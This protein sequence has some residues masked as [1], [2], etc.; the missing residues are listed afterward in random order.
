MN[1]MLRT[2]LP[3]GHGAFY[4]EQ[5]KIKGCDERINIVYD[6][7]GNSE[8][9][10]AHYIKQNFDKGETIHALFIS[11]LH[12]DHINGV[13]E[14]LKYCKVKNIF[15]PLLTDEM[16][17]LTSL[18]NAATAGRTSFSASFAMN[19]LRALA[20]LGFEER[21]KLYQV[22]E[23]D[24][25]RDSN[26]ELRVER[27]EINTINSGASVSTLVNESIS[28]KTNLTDDWVFV[29]FHFRSAQ[30]LKKLK[31][32]L[33]IEFKR[34]MNNDD[35]KKIWESGIVS[36]FDK[37]KTAYE[38]VA[39]DHNIYTMTLYSGIKD[40]SYKQEMTPFYYS[41]WRLCLGCCMKKKSAGCLYMG[42]YNAKGKYRWNAL[43]IAYRAYWECIGCV[44][45]PHH[46]SRH[47]YN[48]ELANLNA[49]F[50]ISAKAH[51]NVHPAPSVV[52]DLLLKGRVPFIV[53]E[54]SASILYLRVNFCR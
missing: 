42:D 6:C 10:V 38:Q 47:N 54:D 53:T 40:V 51:D 37:I 4:C 8:A 29:P 19:P 16:K 33:K 31:D 25:E 20:D 34:D 35:L 11:H 36:E 17:T 13:P 3:V 27:G 1:R 41:M 48:T 39:T 50:V 24:P 43:Y 26:T 44:Q 45:I 2:F 7:G 23:G 32:A 14:L 49:F 22:G 28:A 52:K 15:F 18:Y 46:G 12:D 30:K 5:F 9:H 21:P